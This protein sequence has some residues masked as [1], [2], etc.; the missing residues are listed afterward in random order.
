MSTPAGQAFIAKQPEVMKRSMEMSQ[1]MMAQIMPKI[2][3]I[4]KEM[5]ETAPVSATPE[6]VSK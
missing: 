6:K 4:T 5:I 2:Q 3:A 1:K